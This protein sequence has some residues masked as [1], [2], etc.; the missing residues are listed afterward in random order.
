[1]K[2]LKFLF[3][4]FLLIAILL[5]LNALLD[6][7]ISRPFSLIDLIA[8]FI[9]LPL[10]LLVFR[11]EFRLFDRFTTIRLR[12]K[13]LLSVF[14]FILAFISIALLE[15]IWFETTGKMLF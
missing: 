3:Y 1:M 5:V 6:K 15:N 13:I 9:G 8:I 2:I 10:Y 12:Y 11:L 4:Q 14:A 7:Y